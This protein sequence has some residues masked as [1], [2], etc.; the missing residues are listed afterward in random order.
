MKKSKNLK[1]EITL[2][3]PVGLN[4]IVLSPSEEEAIK[5][6]TENFVGNII[7]IKQILK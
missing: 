2:D 4:P 6:C 5:F 3:N 7:S 1:F